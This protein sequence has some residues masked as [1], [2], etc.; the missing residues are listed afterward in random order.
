MKKERGAIALFVLLACLFFAFILTGIYIYNLNKMQMQNEQ[1]K[2]IQENY[3]KAII[4]E[5]GNV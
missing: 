1:I 4:N 2:Q 5:Q 3:E